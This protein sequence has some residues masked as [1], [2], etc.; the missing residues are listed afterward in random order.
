M[1]SSTRS[2]IPFFRQTLFMEVEQPKKVSLHHHAPPERMALGM[3]KACLVTHRKLE[4]AARTYPPSMLG[5]KQCCARTH[6]LCVKA[7]GL[8]AGGSKS[9]I[10]RSG[11]EFGWMLCNWCYPPLLKAR[12]FAAKALELFPELDGAS[13]TMLEAACEDEVR[14]SAPRVPELCVPELSMLETRSQGKREAPSMPM[15]PVAKRARRPPVRAY[16]QMPVCSRLAVSESSAFKRYSRQPAPRQ[17][18]IPMLMLMPVPT[19]VP[20]PVL[21]SNSTWAFTA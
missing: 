21:V 17:L 8:K 12:H 1:T 6:E 9:A 18:P 13:I 4:Q 7:K 10:F 5:V 11:A 16:D 15:R 2:L 3:A 19:M 20:T 14:G